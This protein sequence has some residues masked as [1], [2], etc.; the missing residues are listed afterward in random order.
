MR[1]VDREERDPRSIELRDEA[2]V[3]EALRRDVENLHASV[4]EPL[5]DVARLL[6]AQ[7]GVEARRPDALTDKG[8]DLV[9]H[10]RDQRRDD[11]RDAVEQ[12]T[13]QLVAEA[14]PR[15]G[16]EHGKCRAALEQRLDDLLLARPKRLVPEPRVERVEHRA[17]IDRCFH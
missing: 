13:W 17:S 7:A 9:L 2:L 12:H 6:R 3:V 10:E 5:R 15:P 1:L 8:V 14:L 11:D 4:P 16:R